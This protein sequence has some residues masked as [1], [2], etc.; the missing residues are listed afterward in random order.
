MTGDEE[1]YLLFFLS[2][3][4]LLND[5]SFALLLLGE[6]IIL[7]LSNDGGGV[8]NRKTSKLRHAIIGHYGKSG[9]RNELILLIRKRLMLGVREPIR[10]GRID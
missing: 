2:E 6:I 9:I 10:G 7:A 8:F 1:R 4:L 3:R 5:V